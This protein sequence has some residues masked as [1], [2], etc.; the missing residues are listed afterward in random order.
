MDDAVLPLCCHRMPVPPAPGAAVR[1]AA[2]QYVPLPL[3]VGAAGTEFTV[4][5]TAK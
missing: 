5:V 2:P 1:V 3:T 4:A